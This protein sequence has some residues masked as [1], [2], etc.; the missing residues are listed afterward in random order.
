MSFFFIKRFFKVGVNGCDSE[1]IKDDSVA[2]LK[3][4]GDYVVA[5]IISTI[6]ADAIK[7]VKAKDKT[8][9]EIAVPEEDP[10]SLEGVSCI[11]TRLS[12]HSE[13]QTFMNRQ[14]DSQLKS[15]C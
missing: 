3:K 7:I 1:G 5:K 14:M 2:Q 4:E 15:S 13:A 6:I 11:E 8:E 9:I 12:T 10:W